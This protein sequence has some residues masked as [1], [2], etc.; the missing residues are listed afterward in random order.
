MEVVQNLNVFAQRI[1]FILKCTPQHL[2]YRS[3]CDAKSFGVKNPLHPGQL[4][5][6]VSMC[7]YQLIISLNKLKKFH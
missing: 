4:W 2:S 5:I 3:E 6:G 1:N 7:N